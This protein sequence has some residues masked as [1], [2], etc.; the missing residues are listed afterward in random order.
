MAQSPELAGPVMRRA[1]SFHPDRR[2]GQPRKELSHLP[3]PERLA[4]NRLLGCIHPVQ[5]KNTLG[6]VHP[7]ADKI[8]HGRLLLYEICNDL[9]LAQRCRR[10]A[11]HPNRAIRF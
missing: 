6:R 7:N 4:Q 11:V 2:R 10:G 9:I 1:T 5:H 3:T 8:V